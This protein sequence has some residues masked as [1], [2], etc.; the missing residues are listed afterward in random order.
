[1]LLNQGFIKNQKKRIE[2]ERGRPLDL[3]N[4]T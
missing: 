3:W 1:I 4:V 2:G